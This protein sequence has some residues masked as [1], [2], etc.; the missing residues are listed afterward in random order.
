MSVVQE[1]WI[2]RSANRYSI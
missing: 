1:N 2:D